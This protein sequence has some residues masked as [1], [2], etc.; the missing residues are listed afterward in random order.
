MKMQF[1]IAGTDLNTVRSY[2]YKYYLDGNTVGSPLH[3]VTVEEHDGYFT[4]TVEIPSE[5]MATPELTVNGT[6]VPAKTHIL[7]ISVLD[8]NGESVKSSSF[9]VEAVKVLPAPMNLRVS[10]NLKVPPVKVQEKAQEKSPSPF[11][12]NP[13]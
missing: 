13:V 10:N 3:G 7:Q 5:A 11:S 8:V 9:T 12:S 1:D 4:G 2:S 6:T